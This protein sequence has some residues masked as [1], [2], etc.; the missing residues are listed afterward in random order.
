[1]LS[2]EKAVDQ[3]IRERITRTLAPYLSLH[4]FQVSV[5]ARLNADKKQTSETIFDPDSRVERSV[6]T[7]KQHQTSSNAAAQKTAGA[8]ANLPKNNPDSETKQS[9]DDSQKNEQVTNYEVSSKSITTT[10]AGFTVEALSVAVLVNRAALTASLGANATAEALDKQ[11]ADIQQIVS[12][13]AGLR[14]DRGDSLK[15]SVVD[16]VDAGKELEPVAGPSI[17]ES[18][19]NH[20]GSLFNAGAVVAVAFMLIMFGVRPVVR[21]LMQAPAMAEHAPALA[22][23]ETVIALE[24]R[25]GAVATASP[26]LIDEK[27]D[28]DNFLDTVL[29][30]RDRTPQRHLLTL[31]DFD[32]AQ[33]AAVLKQWMRKGAS[34]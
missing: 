17:L 28:D 3:D 33:A 8:D 6:R 1:L 14:S 24:H 22:G 18:L 16:F 7:I 20:V 34:A 10:S 25:E 23:G 2:L 32:D 31:V 5:A 21:T 26:L 12:S 15:I 29:A 9:S 19:L 11:V 4:N 30:R 27:P 13:A